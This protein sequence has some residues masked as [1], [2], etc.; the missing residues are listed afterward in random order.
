MENGWFLSLRSELVKVF[1]NQ[2]CQ[3]EIRVLGSGGYRLFFFWHDTPAVREI[4]VCRV[5]PKSSV[6]GKRRLNDVCDAVEAMRKRFYQ[7]GG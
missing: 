5:L 7:E 1:H 3:G 4:W 6:T 2:M